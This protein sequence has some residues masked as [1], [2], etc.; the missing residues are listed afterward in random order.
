MLLEVIVIDF[1]WTFNPTYP[2]FRLQVIWVL[3]LAMVIMS[4]LIYLPPKIILI[5]GLVILFGHNLLDNI[6][7]SDNSF[8]DFL[9]AELHERK[10]FFIAGRQVSTGYPILPWLGIM[11]L[12]YSFGMLYKKG[13]NAAARK[14]YLLLM[15]SAAIVLFLL[16]RGNK[17]LR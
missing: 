1:A 15:G 12:G 6:H 13:M 3:G 16:L 11:I 9:W 4:A 17:Q 5:I 10:R 7:A 14:K 8:K 2:I